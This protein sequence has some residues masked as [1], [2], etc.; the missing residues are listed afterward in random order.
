MSGITVVNM[1]GISSRMPIG[2]NLRNKKHIPISISKIPKR[3]K[4]SFGPINHSVLERSSA[5]SGLA[6]LVP[7]TLRI[8]NQK[9]IINSAMR[10]KLIG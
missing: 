2:F 9:K 5:T 10:E 7:M 3:I 1:C 8:P 6:G 4:N